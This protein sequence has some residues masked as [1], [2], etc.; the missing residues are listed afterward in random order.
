MT[1]DYTIYRRITFEITKKT[2]GLHV[3]LQK[4]AL[5]ITH[6]I[7]KKTIWLQRDYKKDRRITEGFQKKSSDYSGITCEYIRI[8]SGLYYDYIGNTIFY[9]G[10]LK[11][12]V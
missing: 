2:V 9:I 6:G 5:R 7:T 12:E 4:K 3:G 11:K 10:S 8:T 1:W